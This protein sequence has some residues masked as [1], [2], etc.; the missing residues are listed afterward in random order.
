MRFSR[1]R[2]AVCFGSQLLIACDIGPRQHRRFQTERD[3]IGQFRAHR[4]A[5]QSLAG[6]WLASSHRDLYWFGW[7][8]L[9]QAIYTWN[10]LE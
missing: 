3:A 7:S 9:H 1:A 8:D 6:H 2:V 5:Y 4:D 10:Y